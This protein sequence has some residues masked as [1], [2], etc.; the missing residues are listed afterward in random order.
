MFL[1]LLQRMIFWDL[2]KIFVIAFLAITGI[3]LMGGVVAEATQQGVSFLQVLLILPLVITSLLPWI[4]PTTTLFATCLVYGRLSADNEILAIRAAGI[5]LLK[6]VWPAAL[7]GLV[8]SLATMGLYYRFIPYTHHLMRSLLLKDIQEL[9][10]ANLKKDRSI[11]HPRLDFA[12]FVQ[13]IQGRKLMWPIF[14]RRS[15]D[16]T[17]DLVIRAQEA[18]L[19]VDMVRRKI[20]V[21]M[22]KADVWHKGDITAHLRERVEEVDLSHF[23]IN[24]KPPRPRDMTW[25][26]LSEYRESMT[27]AL[28]DADEKIDNAENGRAPEHKPENIG[29]HVADLTHQRRYYEGEIRQVDAEYQMRPAL[30]LGCLC[31]V[32][33]GVPIGIWFSRSDYLSA[34][35]TCFVPIVMVYYPL[36]F[37]GTNLA[38]DGKFPPSI[39]VWAADAIVALIALGLYARLLRR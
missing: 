20:I 21:K 2:L 30:A 4:L 24:Q 16:G 27:Q 18:E 35:I 34:F 25:K 33:I 5:N 3:M 39:A 32:L 22:R 10:L 9:L 29:K 6:V 17:F 12:V 36:M 28:R 14:K 15:A 26:Q 37:A 1:C 7:L 38:K 8:L 19:E 13:D 31:F 11:A 23:L